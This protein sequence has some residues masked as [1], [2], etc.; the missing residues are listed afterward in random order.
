VWGGSAV[1]FFYLN[2]TPN[3]SD[4]NVTPCGMK[5][6]P[7]VTPIMSR[8]FLHISLDPND[9]KPEETMEALLA[10][11][12][13]KGQGVGTELAVISAAIA[14]DASYAWSWFCTAVMCSQEEGLG[15]AAA[16]RVAAR[17]MR[18]CFGVDMTKHPEYANS[19]LPE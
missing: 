17:F 9:P 4:F 10:D 12:A 2:R 13:R 15:R 7:A 18:I 11:R 16:S 6:E 8:S 1:F 14:T 3:M 19:Q 5:S